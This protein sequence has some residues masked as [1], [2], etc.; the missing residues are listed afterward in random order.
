MKS[1]RKEKII[2]LG[3]SSV[4]KTSILRRYKDGSF[5]THHLSTLGVDSVNI[6]V[7]LGEEI[8]SITLWDTA[9]Q[10]RFRT[11]THSFYKQSQGIL[12]VYD[13]TNKESFES[14]GGWIQSIYEHADSNV[15]KYLVGNKCDLVD[16]RK[17]TYEEGL[18][19]ATDNGMKFFETSA[20]EEKNIKEAI[21]CLAKEVVETL[22]KTE[23]NSIQL[24][25]NPKPKDKKGCC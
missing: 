16:D 11:I 4:G 21:E 18:K 19:L 14:I 25:K 10:E 20:K 1:L 13:I 17:V 8:I 3:N 2:C 23:T 6:D 15:V 12:L 24:D 7:T 22:K 5:T 9:G